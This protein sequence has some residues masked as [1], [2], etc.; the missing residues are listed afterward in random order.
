MF[1]PFKRI[2]DKIPDNAPK[3]IVLGV[4]F[5]IAAAVLMA[6]AVFLVQ[7]KWMGLYQMVFALMFVLILGFI[8]CVAWFLV[9][10]M[11]GRKTTWRQRG[12]S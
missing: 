7:L 5:W 9:E 1:A 6:L 12:N 4:F 2:M 3:P 10:F 11:T 8:G